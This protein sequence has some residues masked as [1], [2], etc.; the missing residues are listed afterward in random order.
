M[1]FG[2]YSLSGISTAG[3]STNENNDRFPFIYLFGSP[4]NSS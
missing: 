1:G 4:K 3:R 2:V